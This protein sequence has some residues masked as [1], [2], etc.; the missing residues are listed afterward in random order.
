MA[1][2]LLTTTTTGQILTE[3]NQGCQEPCSKGT[4]IHK[5]PVR[6]WGFILSPCGARWE[7]L[8]EG[9]GK[10]AGGVVVRAWGFNHGA[11]SSIVSVVTH[12]KRSPFQVTGGKVMR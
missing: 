8:R 1:L 12:S 7:S 3:N 4:G 11:T 6:Q 9:T 5:H 2:K 10:P